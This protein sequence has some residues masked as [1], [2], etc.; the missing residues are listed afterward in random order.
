M[1]SL[2]GTTSDKLTEAQKRQAEYNGF[3]AEGGIYAGAAAEYSETYA[4]K[5]AQLNAA[6]TNL[7]LT[8][9]N[10]VIPVLDAIIPHIINVINWFTTLFNYAARVINLLFNTSIPIIQVGQAAQA[11]E[12]NVTESANA[13]EKLGTQTQAIDQIA[14]A[15][16]KGSAKSMGILAEQTEEAGEAAKGALAAF[17]KLNVLQ[18]KQEEPEPGPGPGPMPEPTPPIELPPVEDLTD[19]LQDMMDEFTGGF[20]AFINGLAKLIQTGDWSGI[21]DWFRDYVWQPI[22]DWA[23]NAVNNI[24]DFL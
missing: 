17:D 19:P 5:V 21:A 15:A 8:L 1:Q 9:G 24:L 14:E 2:I 20:G 10:L 13:V 7:K 11:A 12:A 6:M 3:M 4:G 22:T 23:A 18:M 16:G